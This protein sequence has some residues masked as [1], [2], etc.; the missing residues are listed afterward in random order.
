MRRRQRNPA[1]HVNP[2][3]KVGKEAS[4]RRWP[5]S[6]DPVSLAQRRGHTAAHLAQ[7]HSNAHIADEDE[8]QAPED[9]DGA[10]AGQAA[11][12]AL[13]KGRPGAQ[14]GEGER[15]HTPHAELARHGL[16]MTEFCEVLR[17]ADGL[18]G[19]ICALERGIGL[20]VFVH[21]RV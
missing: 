12:Y 21:G 9:G 10:S 2:R 8:A 11:V 4:R 5:Q 19:G 16:V 3:T 15:K 7:R 13:G 20:D 1:G 14:H 18:V 6:R 17:I